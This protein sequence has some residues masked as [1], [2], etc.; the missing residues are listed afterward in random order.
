MARMHLGSFGTHREEIEADFDYFGETIR[1]HPDASDLQ[2][3]ELMIIA[4]GI[5]VGEVDF[6]DPASWTPQERAALEKAQNATI[7][8]IQGQ[9]HPDDWDRFFKVA[10]Q[11]RQSMF[12]LMAVSQHITEAVSNFPT[13]Q[14]SGSSAGRS[15]TRPKSKGGSSSARRVATTRRALKMLESRPDFQM[16]VVAAYEAQR[17][18]EAG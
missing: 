7:E 8:A 16:G 18:T 9:I 4:K 14:P 2:F 1:V 10:K 15:A 6:Q 11:H 13:G 17:S 12:D 5:D 3:A